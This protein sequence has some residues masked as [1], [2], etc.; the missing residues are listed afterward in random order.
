M[1]YLSFRNRFSRSRQIATFMKRA[2][3]E[4]S[5][6]FSGEAKIQNAEW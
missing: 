6:T 1:S 2:I 4:E 3:V 5:I